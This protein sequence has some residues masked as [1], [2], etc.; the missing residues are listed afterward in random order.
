MKTSAHEV[1][2]R[3][4]KPEQIGAVGVAWLVLRVGWRSKWK[5]PFSQLKTDEAGNRDI[6][7][8]CAPLRESGK[9]PASFLPPAD[10]L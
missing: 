8:L 2:I 9:R 10:P 6:P 4:D 5:I 7:M 3:E 1:P